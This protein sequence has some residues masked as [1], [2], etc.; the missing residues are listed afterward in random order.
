MIRSRARVEIRRGDDLS[1]GPHRRDGR[2]VGQVGQVGTREAGG[3]PGQRLQVD[4]RGQALVAAV[5]LQDGGSLGQIGEGD[6]DL[7][8]EPAGP[9]QGR[10]E[11]LGPVG[12]GQHDD[13]HHRVEPVHLRQQL[14]EGLLPL[15]VGGEGAGAGP[16]GADGIDLVDEDDGGS[17][18]AGLGEQVAHPGGADADE[19]LHEAGAGHGEKGDLGLAGDRPGQQG[20]AR[21]GRADHQ[22]A[23]RDG[24]ADPGVALWLSQEVDHLGDL[25][26][27]A[28]VAGDVGKGDAR[29]LGV[30]DLGPRLAHPEHASQ[31]ASAPRATS[32]TTTSRGSGWA[33]AG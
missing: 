8:V 2:L 24:G 21:P 33:G 12:G 7:P 10:V 22:D 20:L 27:G 23:P 25:G 13:P 18:L 5:N 6:G 28:L 30:E 31:L 26:L 14:V 15:V 29:L 11:H 3:G 16:P 4:V 17:P 32:A 1:A 19:E 9:E